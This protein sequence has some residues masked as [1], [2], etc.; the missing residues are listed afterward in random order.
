VFGPSLM[1]ETSDKNASLIKLYAGVSHAPITSSLMYDLYQHLPSDTDFT[2]LKDH[3]I[4]G[5]NLA[6]IGGTALYHRIGDITANTSL[7]SIQHQGEEALALA[8]AL[9]TNPPSEK[10][11]GDVIIFDVFRHV[12][13][14][15]KEYT[16]FLILAAFD[17][18]S[19]RGIGDSGVSSYICHGCFHSVADLSVVWPSFRK[20]RKNIYYFVGLAAVITI[21]FSVVGNYY[22]RDSDKNPYPTNL[23]YAQDDAGNPHWLFIFRKR[24][25]WKVQSLFQSASFSAEPNPQ[26]LIPWLSSNFPFYAAPAPRLP[27]ALPQIEIVSRNRNQGKLSIHARLVSPQNTDRVTLYFSPTARIVSMQIA[28]QAIPDLDQSQIDYFY[29]WHRYLSTPI[30]GGV[31]VQFVLDEAGTTDMYVVDENYGLPREGKALLNARPKEGNYI[32]DFMRYFDEEATA[33]Q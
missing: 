26:K 9:A 25:I 19:L 8:R 4:Q 27:V 12:I 20:S 7:Y 11:S 18:L 21:L 22:P 1:Y 17:A 32:H 16:P 29:G 31:D 33:T 5:F 2:I 6:F 3:G 10:A 24:S 23:M 30:T 14:W 13:W 15:P 28:G